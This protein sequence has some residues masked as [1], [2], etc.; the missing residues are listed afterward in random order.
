MLAGLHAVRLT[1]NG[2]IT[3]SASSI[4]TRRVLAEYRLQH[5][6]RLEMS[7]ADQGRLVTHSLSRNGEG[8]DGSRDAI[9]DSHVPRKFVI[10]RLEQKSILL[11]LEDLPIV[12]IVPMQLWHWLTRA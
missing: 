11:A 7:A 12:Q 9:H 2:T 3:S 8:H 4:L 5:R 10:V 1:C 6:H